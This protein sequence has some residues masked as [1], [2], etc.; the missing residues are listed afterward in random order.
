MEEAKLYF[1]KKLPHIIVGIG[2]LAII[3]GLKIGM[4]KH[5]H[6]EYKNGCKV[7]LVEVKKHQAIFYLLQNSKCPKDEQSVKI[8]FEEYIIPDVLD[9]HNLKSLKNNEFV[10]LSLFD[11]LNALEKMRCSNE[12]CYIDKEEISILDPAYHIEKKKKF[13]RENGV[14]IA[15]HY[16]ADYNIGN[17]NGRHDLS[18]D[19]YPAKGDNFFLLNYKE[20]VNN[21]L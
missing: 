11:D 9:G 8:M 1:I 2:I 20:L 19:F 10:I 18:F 15:E 14:L 21:S 7:E 4:K 17:V 16:V 6:H 3:I 13:A 12:I 5:S